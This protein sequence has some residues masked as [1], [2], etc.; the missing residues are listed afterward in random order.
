MSKKITIYSKV[1]CGQCMFTKKYLD[2]R[3]VSYF[4]KNISENPVWVE[5]VKALGFQSLPV[6]QI[7]GEPPFNGFQPQ[8]LDALVN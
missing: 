3:N 6:I 1:G 2:K 7:E 4:E 8:L 5:E